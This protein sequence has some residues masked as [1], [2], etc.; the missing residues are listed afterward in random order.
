MIRATLAL[1]VAALPAPA[2]AQDG[3]RLAF[4]VGAGAAV[5]P[6]YFGSDQTDVGPSFSF[7]AG[8]VSLGGL[9]F[10]D[11]DPTDVETGLGFRGSFRYVSAR[12][13]GPFEGPGRLAGEVDAAIEVGGGV[14]Y[15]Q[16]WY[17]AFAVARVG[18]GGHDAVVGELG[19]DLIAR[20]TDRLR[21]TAGPRLFYGTDDYA[22]TYFST[23]DDTDAAGPLF[24]AGGGL[25][26]SGVELGA[27]YGLSDRWGL[28]ATARY[29]RFQG[30]AGESPITEED[31]QVSATIELT[32]R[33][34][35]RF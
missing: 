9:S 10:G 23:A 31:D 19:M 11:E 22:G 5:V 6:E 7:D 26:T 3:P 20:P 33:F 24:E 4:T 17:E 27:S 21:L 16:S 15:A 28:Q 2:F 12:Q 34:D 29:D 32:R 18:V 1:L 25:L 30:D 14:R 8:F 35:F 13:G